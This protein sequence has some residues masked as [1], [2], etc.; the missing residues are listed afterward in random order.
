MPNHTAS[1]YIKL[2]K[3][4]PHVEG[5][6]FAE[7]Y[8]S[9]DN[10]KPIDAARYENEERCAGTSIFFLLE[11][12]DFSAWHAL[13]SD[14]IWHFY[15]GSPVQ[16]H[17]IDPK[18]HKL[19]TYL[20]GNPTQDANAI[21]IVAIK[22]GCWFSAEVKDKTSFCLVGCTVNPGFDYKDFQLANRAA[23]SGEYPAYK[24]IIERLTRVT[25]NDFS[26]LLPPLKHIQ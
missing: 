22:A 5:G 10:V 12:D 18:T 8:K 2:L 6:Y 25:A 7:V 24:D 26:S 13:R 20:L 23:L 1:D 11:K 14:E 15:D 16:I 4:H 19:T 9:A 3:L 21:F 17:V